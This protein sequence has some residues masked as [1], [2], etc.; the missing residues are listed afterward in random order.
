MG[1]DL[2]YGLPEDGV[3]TSVDE[4]AEAES[5]RSNS[6]RVGSD[7]LYIQIAWTIRIYSRIRRARS[8][9]KTKITNVFIQ[10]EN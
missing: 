2:E 6:G 8:R 3:M 5:Q 9:E 7:M 1:P 4:V 10:G